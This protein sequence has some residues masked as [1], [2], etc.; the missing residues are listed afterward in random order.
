MSAQEPIPPDDAATVRYQLLACSFVA[1]FLELML[2]RWVPAALE[3]IAY[4]SN[5]LLLSSFFGLGLGALLAGRVRSTFGWFPLLLLGDVVIVLLAQRGTLPSDASEVRF[6]AP[7]NPASEGPHLFNYLLLVS[8]FVANAAVMVPIG[9]RVGE[10][11]GRLPALRA[12][13]YD[14]GGS[15]AGTLAFGAFSWAFFSPIAG[16]VIPIALHAA[17]ATRRQRLVAVPLALATLGLM[18]HA[19]DPNGIWS[20]YY[21]ITMREIGAAE[22]LAEPPP[23][24]RTRMNPPTFTASVNHAFYQVHATLDPARFTNPALTE[25]EEARANYVLP[26]LIRPGAKNTLVLGAG[27][28]LDVEVALLCGVSSVDAVDIDPGLIAIARRWGASGVYD[29]PRVRVRVDD[30]RAFLEREQGTYDCVVYGM[31]DSQALFSTMSNVRLDGYVYTVE[32]IRAGW[33]RVA[34]GGVLS[35]SFYVHNQQWLAARLERLV[36]LATGREP[37]RYVDG[38][39]LVLVV[40]RDASAA[41]TAPPGIPRFQRVDA[42][43]NDE[44]VVVPTDDWPFLYLRRPTIPLDYLV[45]LGLLALVV[46]STIVAARPPGGVDAADA[47]S[48]FLG[49]GFLLLQTKSIT[50]CSIY[51]GATWVVTTAV[52]CGVLL[53]VLLANLVTSASSGR[54]SYLALFAALA[55]VCVVPRETILALPVAGRLAWI[56]LVVPLPI[57]FAGRIFSSLFR[58]SPRPAALFGTNL[59][60]ATLGGFCEYGSMVIGSRGLSVVLFALYAASWVAARQRA[61]DVTAVGAR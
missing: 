49:A 10:L 1:L 28:G 25:F 41:A 34:P 53:M 51:L 21:Y 48:F 32:G 47:Q 39:R 37:L 30:A 31:L 40:P 23:D 29:D 55:V 17:M 26:H 8:V 16:M 19:T 7:S 58:D 9:Q 50:D 2:I 38:R 54:A 22:T 56:L 24:M 13:T 45:V 43:A 36:V 14:L 35:L 44:H 18:R 5:L 20:P 42:I 6:N 61:K 59:L 4:Y 46:T 11:F 15:L 52:I 60:G 33:R 12:Y 27:G 57:F 3:I